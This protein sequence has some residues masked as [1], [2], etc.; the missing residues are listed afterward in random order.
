[1]FRGGWYGRGKEEEEHTTGIHPSVTTRIDAANRD[2]LTLLEKNTFLNCAHWVFLE[3][4]HIRSHARARACTHTNR[5]KTQTVGVHEEAKVDKRNSETGNSPQRAVEV[6]DVQHAFA[7]PVFA[8]TGRHKNAAP[9]LGGQELT[10]HHARALQSHCRE[11]RVV[12]LSPNAV[13]LPPLPLPPVAQATNAGRQARAQGAPAQ[14]A[15]RK[16][17]NTQQQTNANTTSSVRSAATERTPGW[18]TLICVGQARIQQLVREV[19]VGRGRGGELDCITAAST[20][21]DERAGRESFCNLTL[22]AA[23]WLL[24]TFSETGR[25]STRWTRR[26]PASWS[27]GCRSPCRSGP[28]ETRSGRLVAAAQFSATNGCAMHKQFA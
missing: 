23:P 22:T 12:L 3:R 19:V 21:A 2:Q 17:H 26:G 7:S 15:R 16:R 18:L 24:Q 4:T 1:M 14:G 11:L 10:Q 9:V 28:L 5:E 20:N 13:Q 25:S 6:L 27:T 8:G